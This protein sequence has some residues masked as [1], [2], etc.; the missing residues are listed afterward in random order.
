MK[1]LITSLIGHCCIRSSGFLAVLASNNLGFG[2]AHAV[3]CQ[4][5][6]QQQCQEGMTCPNQQHR[7]FIPSQHHSLDTYGGNEK[8]QQWFPCCAGR[9]Q[10]WFLAYWLLLKSAKLL[11]SNSAKRA[12]WHCI[13]NQPHRAF[14]SW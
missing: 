3:I 7:A 9:K 11:A 13:Q 4:T 6:S 2:L 8:V 1:W 5:F 10:P 14:I 12:C